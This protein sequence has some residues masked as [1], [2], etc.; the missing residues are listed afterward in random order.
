MLICNCKLRSNIYIKPGRGR[1][2]ES[3]VM[4]PMNGFLFWAGLD[5]KWVHNDKVAQF[6][7]PNAKTLLLKRK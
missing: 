2:D 1:A 6:F 7:P 4:R 3:W 5:S